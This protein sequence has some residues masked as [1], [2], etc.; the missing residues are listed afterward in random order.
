MTDR[1]CRIEFV[2]KH[3]DERLTKF[4][5][6]LQAPVPAWLWDDLNLVALEHAQEVETSYDRTEAFPI[7]SRRS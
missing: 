7:P 2:R 5:P 4:S 1:S 3:R 6:R